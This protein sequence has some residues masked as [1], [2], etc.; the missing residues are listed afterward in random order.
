MR[1]QGGNAAAPGR[2]KA[3]AGRGGGAQ[4]SG[5]SQAM[6][7]FE[8]QYGEQRVIWKEVHGVL[9]IRREVHVR[10]LQR[11]RAVGGA[12]SQAAG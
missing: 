9:A 12:L 2:F 7:L 11:M 10:A 5:H 4:S 8:L 6:P 3:P 1:V